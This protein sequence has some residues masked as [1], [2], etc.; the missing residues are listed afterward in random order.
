LSAKPFPAITVRGRTLPEVWER[1]L[2][3]LWTEGQTV[4]SEH[5]PKG[6]DLTLDCTMLM[7]VDEPLA[8]PRI[9]RCLP[10]GLEGLWVYVEEVVSGVHDHWINPDAGMWSYTYHQR[11][12]DYHGLDQL[13]G[14]V[15]TLAKAPHSRRAQGIT[16][17]P[18]EDLGAAD[19]PCLQRCWFRLL[20]I[21]EEPSGGY[22]L[23]MNLHWRSRDAFKAAFMNLFAL[24]ELQRR[25]AGQLAQRLGVPVAC[26]PVRDFSDSYHLYLGYAD[27]WQAFWRSLAERT[28]EQRTYTSQF[29]E[30]LFAEARQRLARETGSR[31]E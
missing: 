19:P 17:M 3:A 20:P 21:G 10:D 11:L 2:V 29:A 15:D 27:E 28:F 1:S 31:R 7:V 5:A 4:R 8:E 12:A 16:W 18:A 25:L 30:P 9:H 14:I 13:A 24:T 6:A 26:G 23:V 22:S